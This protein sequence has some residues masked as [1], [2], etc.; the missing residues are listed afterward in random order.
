M[1]MKMLDSLLI[2][3]ALPLLVSFTVLIVLALLLDYFLHGAGL[4]WVGRY[5]GITGTL[6]L[7]LSFVYSARKQKI[8]H[9]GPVRIF[10]QIHCRVGW[11]GTLMLLVHSGVHFNAFLPWAATVLL[12]IVTGSGHVGQYIYRKAKDEMRYGVEDEKLLYWDSLT[13]NALGRW[14]KV[15][16]PLVSL[17]LGIALFHILSIFFL[18]NWK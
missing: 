9:T 5:L 7:L 13:V 12:L 10:L 4:V 8:V 2:R 15:H 17:F 18:W 14:R 3:R 1:E 11:I 16:M 6:F